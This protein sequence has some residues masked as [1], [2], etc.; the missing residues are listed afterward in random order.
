M[1]ADADDFLADR[2]TGRDHPPSR[3][4]LSLRGRLILVVVAFGLLVP[5]AMALR[6]DAGPR[7]VPTTGAV[8][9]MTGP[10]VFGTGG[11]PATTLPGPDPAGEAPVISPLGASPEPGVAESPP[12][13][14]AT[15]PGAS[16][17]EDYEIRPG[18]SWSRI[19][20]EARVSMGSL[21]AVNAATVDTVLLVGRTICLPRGARTP[22]VPST[23]PNVATTT[24]P[25]GQDY[26]IRAGDSWSRIASAAQVSLRELLAVNAATVDT[27]LL[28]GRTICLPRGARTPPV[29]TTTTVPPTSRAPVTTTVPPAATTV[30][31]SADEVRRLIAEIWPAD[32]VEEAIAVAYRESRLVN[33]VRNFCCYG[34]FQIYFEVHRSWLA[35]LGVT[36][37]EQL[38]EA[39][40]N[41]IAAWTLYQRAGGWGPWGL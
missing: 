40:T 5:V 29:P 32:L 27:V 41:V 13:L 19:A 8:A 16:C 18:D 15:S 35:G 36:R 33:T 2:W 12:T 25:C 7:A 26:A 30:R 17:G 9:L 14:A 21:L 4:R 39:R 11:A 24:P 3:R 37:A 38:Y 34:L 20:S 28:V 10:G 31:V 6:E 23:T 1:T 22:P